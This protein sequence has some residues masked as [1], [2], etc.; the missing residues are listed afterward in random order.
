VAHGTPGFDAR[1]RAVRPRHPER[2]R[3][4]RPPRLARLVF[5]DTAR[6][7]DLEA[8]LHPA[9]RG[10]I[11]QWFATLDKTAFPFAIADIPL[12]YETGLDK[13]YDA[14]IV[15]SCA[16]QTQV[17][18]IMARDNL[19]ATEV[20]HRLD[21]QMPLDDKVKRATYVIDTNG[22]LVQTNAQVHKLYKDCRA[23]EA[24]RAVGRVSS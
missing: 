14:V 16:P 12:L 3:R 7:R 2:R 5:A 15:T 8:I 9:I 17:K 19:D 13:E 22:S 24:C 4:S 6:R 1:R 11:D 23:G 20:Q 10:A 18:R 21:A